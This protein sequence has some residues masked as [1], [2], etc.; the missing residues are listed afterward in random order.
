[1]HIDTRIQANLP[2]RYYNLANGDIPYCG[3]SL[4]INISPFFNGKQ[5]VK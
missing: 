3:R 1:M 4:L 5:R 2:L